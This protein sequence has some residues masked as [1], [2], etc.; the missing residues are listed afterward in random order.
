MTDVALSFNEHW[1]KRRISGLLDFFLQFLHHHYFL[2]CYN[3]TYNKTNSFKLRSASDVYSRNFLINEATDNLGAKLSKYWGCCMCSF[4]PLYNLSISAKVE[5]E[6][7]NESGST[8][9]RLC[10]RWLYTFIYRLRCALFQQIA[11]L[12]TYY[13][14]LSAISR[15]PF[16]VQL[17]GIFFFNRSGLEKNLETIWV[18][19]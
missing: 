19:L 6:R 14:W 16:V 15:K 13:V 11:K 8:N 10:C 12:P 9:F 17:R 18:E 2:A 5:V 1:D 4:A 7:C 3:I